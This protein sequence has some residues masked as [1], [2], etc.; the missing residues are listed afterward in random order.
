MLM[1][2]NL[3]A[4]LPREIEGMVQLQAEEISPFPAERTCVAWELL[5]QQDQFS[6]VLMC[7]CA[8]KPLDQLHDLYHSAG[9]VPDRV[10]IDVLGWLALIKDAGEL[11]DSADCLLLIIQDGHSDVVAWQKGQPC[12]IRSLVKAS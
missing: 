1:V 10:D 11:T 3:P 2:L 5:E 9:L 12:L 4:T 8:R 7:L 6:R